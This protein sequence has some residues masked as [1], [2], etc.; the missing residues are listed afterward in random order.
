MVKLARR[1]RLIDVAQEAG[2]S[3]TTASDA[4][5]DSPRVKFETREMVKRVAKTLRYQPNRAARDLVLQTASSVSVIFSGPES[6]NFLSN[7]FFIQLFRP[8]VESLSSAGVSVITEITT[9]SN[10]VKTLENHSFGS[11]S[12][13]II[14]I[15]T[16]MPDDVLEELSRKLPVPIVT[17]VRHPLRGSSFGVEVDNREIGSIA[18]GHLLDLGHKRIAYIGSSPGVGLSE[19]RLSGFKSEISRRGLRLIPDDIFPGDFYQE[20]GRLAM[21]DII[22]AGKATAVFA[23][24]DLMALGALEACRQSGVAVPEQMSILGCDDIPNLHLL[25]VPLSSISLPIRDIG[26]LAAKQAQEVVENLEP[27]GPRK[28]HATLVPRDSTAAITAE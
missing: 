19:E 24:N 5:A 27:S 15:G 13:A 20:S 21:L 18:A 8:V 16:R 23:A 25:S 3:V 14:L 26:V 11:S 28:L 4:L 12:A 6:M 22:E 7:P 9:E 17:V 1:V 2:V 10:E